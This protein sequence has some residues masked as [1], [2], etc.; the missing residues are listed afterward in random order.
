M[1]EIVT[2]YSATRYYLAGINETLIDWKKI[3]AIVKI[4]D[5]DV[6]GAIEKWEDFKLHIAPLC[7]SGNIAF[8]G[9]ASKA[10]NVPDETI[11]RPVPLV[12]AADVFNLT[13]SAID[14]GFI[15]N[16]EKVW[17]PTNTDPQVYDEELQQALG[18]W[19]CVADFYIQ[20]LDL[21]YLIGNVKSF[22]ALH[23]IINK[24]PEIYNVAA[25]IRPAQLLRT[26]GQT[27]QMFPNTN[28][29]ISSKTEF[30]ILDSKRIY[31]VLQDEFFYWV[32]RMEIE[33]IQEDPLLDFT[34]GST[35]A[36][37]SSVWQQTLDGFGEVIGL[38]EITDPANVQDLGN[39]VYIFDVVDQDR[40]EPTDVFIGL[41]F[42]SYTQAD[43]TMINLPLSE[44]PNSW[45]WNVDQPSQFGVTINDPSSPAPAPPIPPSEW[46]PTSFLNVALYFRI[47][48]D[49]RITP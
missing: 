24:I 11:T 6:S 22:C 9:S 39:P 19:Y 16:P 5:S 34:I 31:D 46:L 41:N 37:V 35:K 36:N 32:S 20:I 23:S 42:A 49:D 4:L 18:N 43:G 13:K 28:A 2:K 48:R 10:D 7:T 45:T 21:L 12:Q 3:R 40:S 47:L 25:A 1:S 30:T 26:P 17:I 27:I 14:N 33:Y 15:L 29:Y 44:A 38:T 8:M